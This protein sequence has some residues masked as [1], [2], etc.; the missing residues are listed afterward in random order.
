VARQTFD[1]ENETV[2]MW[3][4]YIENYRWEVEKG[5]VLFKGIKIVMLL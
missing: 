4:A 2:E 3:A 1:D 5:T